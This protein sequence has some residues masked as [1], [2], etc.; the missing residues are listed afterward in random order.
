MDSQTHIELAVEIAKAAGGP[1]STAIASLFPQI[2]RHPPTLHRLYAH[3]VFKALPITRFGLKFMTGSPLAGDEID[4]FEHQRFQAENP[5]F[6]SYLSRIE[7]PRGFTL[8]AGDELSSLACYVSHL[9][10][11][12]FNQPT[13]PFAPLNIYCSGQ[14][15]LWK[16]LGDFRLRLYT[17]NII[18]HLRA[19][20]FAKPFWS[21]WENIPL[22]AFIQAM[23]ERMCSFSEGKIPAELV[24]QGLRALGLPKSGAQD[25]SKMVELLREFERELYGLHQK[26]LA[27]A[28]PGPKKDPKPIL[29]G[30]AG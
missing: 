18:D 26:H 25:V 4:G 12:S 22:P 23:M 24:D 5:R 9:Y 30:G 3:T 7:S 29:A 28:A 1:P 20:L 19:E 2:D 10:L 6:Q 14:W 13:Q 27:V 16:E 21:R 11:D 17:T 15:E 8:S